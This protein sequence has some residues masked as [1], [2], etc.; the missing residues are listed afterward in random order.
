MSA[1]ESF[2]QGSF[3]MSLV[4]IVAMGFATVL[5]R[6]S[7]FWLMSHVTLT[8]RIR[9]MLEA[10]PGSIAAAMVLPIVVKGGPVAVLGVAVAASLM[11]W[12]GNQILAV[13]SGVLVAA[14]A[15]AMV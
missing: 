9:R 5:M 6:T 7:G 15:R 1:L 14:L 2:T 3:G 12:R 11:A 10:L 13:A 4:A 8:P